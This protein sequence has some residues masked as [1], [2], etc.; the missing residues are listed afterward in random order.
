MKRI[1]IALISVILA[2]VFAPGAGAVTEA[3]M[4]QA[5][6]ISAQWYLRYMNNGS[7]YL[8]GLS[9]KNLTELEKKLKEKEKENIKQFKKVPV[10]ADYPSWDK[11]RLAEYWSSTAFSKGLDPKAG[12]AKSKIRTRINAMKVSAPAENIEEPK[13]AEEEKE[14][15][16]SAADPNAP[17]PLALSQDAPAEDLTASDSTPATELP[18]AEPQKQSG[19]NTWVYV[20]ILVILVIIVMGIIIYAVNSMNKSRREADS[21]SMAHEDARRQLVATIAAKDDEI[22]ALQDE[23]AS[24]QQ[25]IARMR[26]RQPRPAQPETGYRSRPISAQNPR[27]IWLAQANR[28]GIFVRAD[29][30]YNMGNSIFKLVTTD[31]V[32]GTYSVI[33]D[34]VVFDLAL[35]VPA[36]YLMTA[37]IGDNLQIAKGMREIVNETPGTA[38]FEDGKWRVLR[39]ARIRYAR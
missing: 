35:T 10:P 17:D 18:D 1:C 4:E 28:S 29:G 33:E 23:V 5:R 20:V 6:A 27:T 38:I 25:E 12:G 3:E 30:K 16:A 36:D 21:T 7:D 37:C 11:A 2:L 9:P 8:E 13:V 26:A 39:K 19:G 34:P 22:A 31:G 14:N 15:V 32:S 24:L